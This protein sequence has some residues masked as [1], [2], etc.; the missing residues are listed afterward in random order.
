MATHTFKNEDFA[1]KTK[2]TIELSKSTT[3]KETFTIKGLEQ[4]IV[5]IDSQIAKLN[6]KKT[7]VETKISDAK[8]ALSI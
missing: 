8:T 3:V 4:E 6:E 2:N 5:N 1:D 7:E